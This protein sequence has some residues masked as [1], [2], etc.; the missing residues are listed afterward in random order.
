MEDAD[1]GMQGM[2]RSAARWHINLA[3]QESDVV[4]R[5]TTPGNVVDGGTSE[6]FNFAGLH[7]II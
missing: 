6:K 7:S 5:I 4:Q 2:D 1:G 3:L